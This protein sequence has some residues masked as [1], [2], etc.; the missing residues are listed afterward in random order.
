MSQSRPAGVQEKGH[1]LES[2]L[3]PGSLP[4]SQQKVPQQSTKHQ[5]ME[6]WAR[7][8]PSETRALPGV[9]LRTPHTQQSGQPP[10]HPRSF[11]RPDPSH[12]N[13]S[14]CRVSGRLMAPISQ[15]RVHTGHAVASS[16]LSPRAHLQGAVAAVQVVQAWG[17]DELLKGTTQCLWAESQKE[18]A[19]SPNSTC[20]W[21]PVPASLLCPQE[22]P[23]LI[24]LSSQP[25]NAS[26]K[27]SVPGKTCA[28]PA[29][30]LH[31]GRGRFLPLLTAGC[32]SARHSSSSTI[33]SGFTPS[34]GQS[35]DSRTGL[36][37]SAWEESGAARRA[38]SGWQGNPLLPLVELSHTA[39]RLAWS[40]LLLCPTVK[41]PHHT[42]HQGHWQVTKRGSAPCPRC[43]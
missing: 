2:H 19:G 38:G 9:L 16:V 3:N 31:A 27:G 8:L 42:G 43:L 5:G 34:W 30:R 13:T 33:C 28:V 36:C 41:H 4:V 23:P 10:S 20:H 7:T 15:A 14:P 12:R 39:L 17:E 29:P 1:Q 21:V 6:L 22:L 24:A 11:N 40:S 25:W 32:V 37:R 35:R 18:R 26:G